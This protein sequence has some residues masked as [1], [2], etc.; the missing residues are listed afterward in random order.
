MCVY[1]NVCAF[2]V[3]S[4]CH[5]LRFL[6]LLFVIAINFRIFCGITY[7]IF[8]LH[9]FSFWGLFTCMLICL[10]LRDIVF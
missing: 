7:I 2:S 3:Y 10:S 8:S 6:D 5:S 9:I 1:M 4:S